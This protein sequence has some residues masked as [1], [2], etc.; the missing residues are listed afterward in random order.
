MRTTA[1][2]VVVGLVLAAGPVGVD[3]HAALIDPPSRNAVDRLL[4]QF[5]NGTAPATSCSCNCGDKVNG[6]QQGI[7]AAGGGQPCLWFSQGTAPF[8]LAKGWATAVTFTA[9][10]SSECVQLCTTT[11]G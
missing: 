4:P 8:V 7:R 1:A 9:S 6:C 5:R 10:P 11:L 2:A 3:A